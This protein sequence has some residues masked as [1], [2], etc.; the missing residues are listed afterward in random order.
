MG[1]GRDFG[2]L[3]LTHCKRRYIFFWIYS[4]QIVPLF[5]YS[6]HSVMDDLNNRFRSL[7]KEEAALALSHY[8]RERY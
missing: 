5:N 3:N 7:S 4:N 8:C 2:E 6:V 1:E